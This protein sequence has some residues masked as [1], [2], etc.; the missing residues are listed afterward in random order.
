MISLAMAKPSERTRW[1]KGVLEVAPT[2]EDSLLAGIVELVAE[3]FRH[4]AKLVS[5]ERNL[6]LYTWDPTGSELTLRFTDRGRRDASPHVL[7]MRWL[8]SAERHEIQEALERV[9]A[10]GAEH[11]EELR[12]LGVYIAFTTNEA[13][14]GLEYI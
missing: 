12:G 6:V 5:A 11:V 13:D 7:T 10:I 2:D 4:A 8:G 9:L 14:A 3:T 1:R